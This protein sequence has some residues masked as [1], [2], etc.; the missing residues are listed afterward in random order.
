MFPKIADLGALTLHTYGLLLAVAFLTGIW[1]SARLGAR[2]GIH[3]DT[4]WNLG[5][6]IIASSLIGSK[7]LLIIVE[8]D[9]YSRNPLDIFSLDTLR[10]GGVFLGGLLAAII[11]TS[12]YF[13]RK[14]LPGWKLAD[15]FAPG[16][17]LGHAIGRVGCFAAGCCWGTAC[18]LPWAV[19]FTNEYAH[20]NVG[21]PLNIPLHPTQLYE[22]AA[23]LFIFAGLMRAWRSR[24]FEGQVILLYLMSYSVIRFLLEFLRGDPNGNVGPLTTS[25]FISVIVF[26]TSLLLYWKRQGQVVVPSRRVTAQKASRQR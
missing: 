4:V 26:A 9:Y 6:L 24:R 12:L 18:S 11:A 25:Q 16:L 1:L 19:T 22:S 3:P 14:K 20:A 17:A 13:R 15:V 2:D 7:L 10:S 23:E 5:L 21:V 8:W